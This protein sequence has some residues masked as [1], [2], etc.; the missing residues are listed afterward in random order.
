MEQ[1]YAITIFLTII[2]FAA[3]A[4]GSLIPVHRFLNREQKK[5]EAWNEEIRRSRA[6]PEAREDAP[7]DLPAE[8]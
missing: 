1:T 3:L 8:R 2:G 6:A 4:A 5:A 7:A